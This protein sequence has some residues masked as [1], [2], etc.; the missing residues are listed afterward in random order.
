MKNY[1]FYF[2][3]FF[4]SYFSNAQQP[5]L[6]PIEVTD[7]LKIKTVGKPQ[8]SPDGLHVLF[9]VMEIIDDVDKKGDFAYI[10]QLYLGDVK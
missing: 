10:T 1:A 4:S 7:M 5:A 6:S 3:L 8:I 9:S 2:L